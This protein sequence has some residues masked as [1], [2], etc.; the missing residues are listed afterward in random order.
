[1][2]PAGGVVRPFFLRCACGS[3]AC[4]TNEC[5]CFRAKMGCV[6]TCGKFKL[7]APSDTATSIQEASCRGRCCLSFDWRN[8]FDRQKVMRIVWDRVCGEVENI[9]PG[10][11]FYACV[12]GWNMCTLQDIFSGRTIAPHSESMSAHES[13]RIISTVLPPLQLSKLDAHKVIVDSGILD[14]YRSV[15]LR[16]WSDL[17][18]LEAL[19]SPHVPLWV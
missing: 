8:E 13:I 4:K 9:A 17:I 19:S 14:E 5:E 15:C 11:S 18:R 6:T 7:A 16:I 1:M 12:D 3:D 10:D 2:Y